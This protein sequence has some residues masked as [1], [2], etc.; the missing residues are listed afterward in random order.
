MKSKRG[1][2][3]PF[4]EIEIVGLDCDNSKYK[5]VT[6]RKLKFIP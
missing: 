4:V 6:I 2:V 5:T 1:L 3:S